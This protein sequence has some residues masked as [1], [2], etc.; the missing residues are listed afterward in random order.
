MKMQVRRGSRWALSLLA[1][2]TLVGAGGIA[3]PQTLRA[4]APAPLA[5]EV[6][7]RNL[8]VDM[9][10][11]EARARARN[12]SL[13]QELAVKQDLVLLKLAY[14]R[15][16]TTPDLLLLLEEAAEAGADVAQKNNDDT[17]AE[18]D[19]ELA[20]SALKDLLKVDPA[21]MGAQVKLFDLLARGK[22]VDE[23]LSRVYR[24]AFA[25]TALDSQVRSQLGVRVGHLLM[26]RH[27]IQGAAKAFQDSIELNSVN[28]GAWQGLSQLLGETH[29]PVA[30]RM[31]AF[32]KQ[33]NAN[34][35]QPDAWI[36]G[37]RL[38]AAAGQHDAA[39]TWLINGVEQFRMS[40][41]Q[42][43]G[44]IY[45]D[46]ATEM[47]LAKRNVEA[48]NL[49]S[50]LMKIDGGPAVIPS[51]G[52]VIKSGGVLPGLKDDAMFAEA[53]KRLAAAVDA[54]STEADAAARHTSALVEAVWFDLLA[55]PE[56]L[57]Q[58]AERLAALRTALG[59]TDPLYLRLV[60]WQE[61]RAGQYDQ[62]KTTLTPLAQNDPFAI[63]GL[64]RVA[65][66]QDDS[67][68]GRELVA[69]LWDVN[70]VGIAALVVQGEAGRLNMAQP[71]T[72]LGAQLQ[73]MLKDIPPSMMT[74]H[75]KPAD[76]L[77]INPELP[78]L[79][80]EFGEPVVMTVKFINS[81]DH[82]VSVGADGAINTNVVLGGTL[83]GLG[84]QDMGV[85]AAENNPRVFR[86]ERRGMVTETV[87]VDQG[88][89]REI[90]VYN[91]T[92]MISVALN[93]TSVPQPTQNGGW[94]PGLSGQKVQ[95]GQ[96]NRKPIKMQTPADIM[97]MIHTLVSKPVNERMLVA[98]ALQCT[99]NMLNEDQT[100][101]AGTGAATQEGGISQAQIRAELIKALAD[102]IKSGDPMVQTWLVR[103]AP[104]Q[105]PSGIEEA[106]TT[107]LPNATDPVLRVVAMNRALN[108]VRDKPA[109]REALAKNLVA[110]SAAEKDPLV[111]QWAELLAQE[112]ALPPPRPKP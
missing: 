98:G 21:H 28:V 15:D 26:E 41:V 108:L 20:K 33:L 82:A 45:V 63:L 22:P 109:E 106:L 111:K 68:T 92:R 94:A 100:A 76:M 61:L 40:G 52:Y 72:P 99:V 31:T 87:R 47:G 86:V 57:P 37:A 97:D 73:A 27:D 65:R 112:A 75:R 51:I 46:L 13:P 38:L 104:P 14:Q 59:E 35:F 93:I 60:G 7:A 83:R 43:P 5:A 24:P 79:T 55:S 91:P 23:Q 84:A 1:A 88:A 85:F 16:K 105:L 95:A 89:L 4:E 77:L 2:A 39:T 29:A 62:A 70:P 42:P 74:A 103:W 44:D 102:Q 30:D 101:I 25:A 54:K 9:L 3:G 49:I 80:Y 56:V 6:V 81:T 66:M 58:T 34:P 78:K 50:D 107:V 48:A 110:V 64:L 69:K 71:Q 90:M 32:V 18:A 19:I 12:P 53:Q 36:T 10:M 96:F 8:I 67:K 11:D 17:L